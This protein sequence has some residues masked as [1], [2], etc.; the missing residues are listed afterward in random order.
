MMK[1]TISLLLALAICL[2]LCGC[3]PFRKQDSTPMQNTTA[4]ASSTIP[5]ANAT[6]DV[7]VE[8]TLPSVKIT[9]PKTLLDDATEDELQEGAQESGMD[10][11]V[12]NN[13]G[14]VTYTMTAAKHAELL[15]ELSASLEAS[16]SAFME[17]DNPVYSFVSID[18][19]DDFSKIDIY[20]ND[21]YNE[22]DS[23]YALTFYLS[24][25]Y[26]QSFAGVATND[27]DVTVNFINNDTKEIL[28]TASYKEFLNNE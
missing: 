6:E 25:A 15:Q 5:D 9:I 24:G 4:A 11:C 20:V 12:I 21:L 1:K 27:I 23:I 7:Q 28:N 13:D 16:F 2:S 8:E 19:T 17:G 3:G 10:Q 26:Y 18:H 14:S 22:W